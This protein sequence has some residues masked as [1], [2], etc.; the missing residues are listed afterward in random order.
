MKSLK[1]IPYAVE[2][3]V[4]A[5]ME[6]PTTFADNHVLLCSFPKS[7]NTWLRFIFANM[8]R[9]IEG[10]AKEVDFHSIDY[11][12]PVIRGNRRLAEISSTTSF[13]IFLK[14]HFPWIPQFSKYRSLLI[15]REPEDVMLSYFIYLNL[16]K[17]KKLPDLPLFIRHWRYGVPAWVHYHQTWAERASVIIRYEDL[18]GDTVGVVARAL[19]S[20]GY[21]FPNDV[22]SKAVTLSS[23]ENMRA[24][25]KKGGDPHA[26][27]KDFQFVRSATKGQ[28]R[29]SLSRGDL[30]YVSNCS[31]ELRQKLRDKCV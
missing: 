15:A 13:P 20:L 7:G 12:A 22:I 26:R 27:N 4:R 8:L 2:R 31:K 9:V 23:K 29:K 18:L 10:G 24:A 5:P 19:S 17:G 21:D 3:I 1:Q 16:E 14:T 28:G 6:A 25:L 11:Y 30:R